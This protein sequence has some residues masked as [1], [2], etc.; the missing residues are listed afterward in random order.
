MTSIDLSGYVPD[1]YDGTVTVQYEESGRLGPAAHSD[2]QFDGGW[3]YY[4][5]HHPLSPAQGAPPAAFVRD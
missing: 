1:D 2:V 5:H 3:P 4:G